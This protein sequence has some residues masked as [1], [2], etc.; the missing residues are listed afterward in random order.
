[1]RSRVPMAVMLC[2]AI[3]ATAC[4]RHREPQDPIASLQAPERSSMYDEAFWQAEAAAET[5][6][7]K[8]AV[9]FCGEA[10]DAALPNCSTVLSASFISRLEEAAAQPFPEYGAEPRDGDLEDRLQEIQERTA[11]AAAADEDQSG[12]S[13]P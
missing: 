5:E 3:A 1:M 6:L 9:A 11:P 13:S 12:D 10:S 8:A 4:G 7:W 2:M